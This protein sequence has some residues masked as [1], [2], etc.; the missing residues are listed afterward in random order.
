MIAY[1]T[2]IIAPLPELAAQDAAQE[3]AIVHASVTAQPWTA[4][5]I[6]RLLMAPATVGLVARGEH[7]N[8]LGF[9][10]AQRALD[11]AEILMVA[12]QPSAQRQGM[13]RRLLRDLHQAVGLAGVTRVFLEVAVDNAPG[14]GLYQSMGY[15]E[16][17]RRKGYYPNFN[18]PQGE[19]RDALILALDLLPLS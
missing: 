14:L 9:I 16:A 17:G 2:F 19:N 18:N 12:V 8:P 13:G 5:G 7:S 6:T 4:K 3:V 10:L 1:D 11:E 15:R